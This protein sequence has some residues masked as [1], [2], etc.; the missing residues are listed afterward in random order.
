MQQPP[1]G[2]GRFAP[3]LER[4]LHM[5]KS[6]R[7]QIS[8]LFLIFIICIELVSA[9]AGIFITINHYHSKFE[10]TVSDI[11]TADFK[12]SLTELANTPVSSS[13]ADSYGIVITDSSPVIVDNISKSI[14]A[15]RDAFSIG[16]SSKLYILDRS[17]AVA[18]STD[19]EQVTEASPV[20]SNALT[21]IETINSGFF[22]DTV[23][24]ALPLMSGNDV[25]YVVYIKDFLVFQ[26]EV[27]KRHIFNS[28][29]LILISAAL[30][31]I[32]GRFTAAKTTAP[33]KTV[34]EQ[35]RRL[36][37]GEYT[38]LSRYDR[39][40]EIA[41]L[42]EAFVYLADSKK[43][44][45][46]KETAEKRKIETILQ[47]M[48][49][50]IL[51]FDSSGA[52]THINREAQRLLNR[53]FVDDI[54][55]NLFFKEINVDI[56][57]EALQYLNS[58]TSVEREITIN[59]NVLQMSFASFSQ[60]SEGGVIVI[61]HDITKQDHL[62]HAR[63][64]FVANVS[65]ELR[66]PLTVIK[67][68]ADMLADTPDADSDIRTRFLNTISSETDRMTK[69]IEDLLTLSKLDV[70]AVYE[71][72][73]ED[74]NIRSML[75]GLV[76]RLSLTAKKKNQELTYTPTND[77]PII[78]GD[79]DGLERV[80]TNIISNALKYTPSGGT[81]HIFTSRVYNDI[82]IK[83]KDTGIGIPEDK[84]PKIFDRFYR[85]DKARSREKGG[86]G[87]GLAIAKQTI[88]TAF[89]GKIL[90]TSKLNKGTEVVV[91]IPLPK[92]R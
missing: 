4:N 25:K 76:E 69:I 62:E 35:A 31:W 70:N 30:A 81:I 18:Y 26:S 63:Q 74:I 79:R 66:T 85:V 34:S 15:Y 60:N 90:I 50:G 59:D 8:A 56:T 54:T 14:L 91:K 12:S 10:D 9:I 43:E 47:N 38:P 28:M 84:L 53:K 33:L 51:A 92:T 5:F 78:T 27:L 41:E 45:A 72:P 71:R 82:L 1:E 52:L 80:F 89:N 57:L 21:G 39:L 2:R 6:I 49:D 87:L 20:I 67:S 24:Y 42:K 58:D 32:A 17:G 22:A 65:H 61:I 44:H 73:T 23:E 64:D 77:I 36:A 13:S 40:S 83:V 48:N 37:K 88:E 68:Y 7:T 46:D 19:A 29:L 86:T 75:E 11:F 3:P 16:V 55:F